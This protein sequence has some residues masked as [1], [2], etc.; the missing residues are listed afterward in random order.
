DARA[1]SAMGPLSKRTLSL[2]LLGFPKVVQFRPERPAATRQE[3]LQCFNADAENLRRF[4]VAQL[5]I[6]AQDNGGALAFRQFAQGPLEYRRQH[7]ALVQH[8]GSGS[9]IGN[10]KSLVER[11]LGPFAE[12]VVALVKSD[13]VKPGLELGPARLPARRVGPEPHEGVLHGV[14]GLGLV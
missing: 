4:D 3:R 9:R 8:G 5:L 2:I 11:R 7:A 6:V 12:A 1:S 14:L 13:A 10:R